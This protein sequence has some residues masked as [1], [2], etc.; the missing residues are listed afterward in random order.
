MMAPLWPR[1]R[2]ENKDAAKAEVRRQ[3]AEKLFRLSLKEMHIAQVRPCP[4]AIGPLNTV[5]D[6]VNAHT[7]LVRMGQSIGGEEV[8]VT[9]ANFER[10][11]GLASEYFGDSRRE[12]LDTLVRARMVG[13]TVRR[14]N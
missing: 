1:V 13:E 5:H 14:R 12:K 10:G 9:A 6:Q 4:L 2:E 8:A 11:L 7:P 3:A